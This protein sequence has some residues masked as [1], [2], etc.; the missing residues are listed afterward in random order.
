LKQLVAGAD[1]A[2][3]RP[4]TKVSAGEWLSWLMLAGALA[5]FGVLSD[6]LA[7]VVLGAVFS[8]GCVVG[9]L[10]PSTSHRPERAP[11]D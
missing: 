11:V 6:Q 8:V 1:G 10:W 3:L 5:I 2:S 4:V 7:I 9:L